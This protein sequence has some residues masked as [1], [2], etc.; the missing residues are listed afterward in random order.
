MKRSVRSS[1]L[2]AGIVTLLLCSASGVFATD[3]AITG[4]T[5]Q[6]WGEF[7]SPYT[8]NNSAVGNV[9]CDDFQDNANIGTNYTY[10]Q[11]SANSLISGSQSGLWGA[12]SVYMP[13]AYMALQIFN[14]KGNIVLTEYYNW[15]L[16]SYFDPSHALAAMNSSGVTQAGCNAIFGAGAFSGGKCSYG[17]GGLIGDAL[18]KA[19]AAY[20]SGAFNNLVV[21][22]P[23]SNQ[24]Q[25]QQCGLAGTC[26]SQ[27]FFG[28]VQVPEGGAALTY[29]LLAGVTCFG[30]IVYS[31]RRTTAGGLA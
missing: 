2:L 15:A 8:T 25:N 9:V 27:E 13:A 16:W 12:G 10:H 3:F 20:L 26:M 14:S 1:W 7:T 30:A 23:G 17:T 28:M 31:R 22:T 21:Y 5:G 11:S 4:S 18:A 24:N 19:G 29:L 6:L